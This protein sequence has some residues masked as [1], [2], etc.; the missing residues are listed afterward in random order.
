VKL[1]FWEK[2]K[3]LVKSSYAKRKYFRDNEKSSYF[4]ERKKEKNLPNKSNY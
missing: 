3:A 4:F 1:D 2:S